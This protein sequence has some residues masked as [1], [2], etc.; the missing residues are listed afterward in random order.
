MSLAHKPWSHLT[1]H[2][3]YELSY[4]QAAKAHDALT[5]KG[6]M[7]VV[8]ED[9]GESTVR[10]RC[11]RARCEQAAKRRARPGIGN[12][13]TRNRKRASARPVSEVRGRARQQG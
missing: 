4:L 8:Q 12:I 5:V 1:N 13:C 6:P 3:M 9:S 2:P 10:A 11:S 7:L